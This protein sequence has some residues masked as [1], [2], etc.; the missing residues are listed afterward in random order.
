MPLLDETG[1][2]PTE[3]YARAPELFEHSQRIRKL[4]G[5]YGKPLFQTEVTNLEWDEST[6]KWQVGTHRGDKINA[7][8]ITTAGGLLHKMKFRSFI[9]Y[10]QIRHV[11]KE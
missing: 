5:L 2:V 3:K 10:V 8:F 7:Q 6:K 9:Y 4:F 11:G 1:Y